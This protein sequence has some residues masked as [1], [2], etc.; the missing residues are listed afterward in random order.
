MN[1]RENISIP[2]GIT[3]EQGI[4]YY[5]IILFR[6]KGKYPHHFAAPC[7]QRFQHK[8]GAAGDVHSIFSQAQII[9]FLFNYCPSASV[10]AAGRDTI[11]L[12]HGSGHMGRHIAQ[13]PVVEHIA[14]HAVFGAGQSAP[15][16]VAV[17]HQTYP[18]YMTGRFKSICN[19]IPDFPI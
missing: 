4:D 13:P 8:T 1:L 12:Q 7:L 16:Q 3:P 10:Q 2:C 17:E 18:A 11:S 15:V 5:I 14:V 6:L 9:L 19:P